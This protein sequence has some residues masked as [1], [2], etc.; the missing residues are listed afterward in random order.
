MKRIDPADTPSLFRRAGLRP[1]R[2]HFYRQA[3]GNVLT[4]CGCLTTALLLD[5]TPAEGRDRVLESCCWP[6]APG[7]DP[8]GV[9][10]ARAGFARPYMHGLVGGWDGEID[11]DLEANV[12]CNP[13]ATPAVIAEYRAGIEDGQAAW[14]AVAADAGEGG[15]P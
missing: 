2:F 3:R 4:P 13:D 15:V 14:D 8:I 7:A 9:L 10:A 11:E 1:E 5:A 12:L 6:P